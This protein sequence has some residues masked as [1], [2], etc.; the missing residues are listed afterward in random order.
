[1]NVRKVTNQLIEYAEEGIINWE[2]LAKSALRYMS[3]YEVAE[4][5]STEGYSELINEELIDEY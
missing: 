4:M 1:M 5:S 3:E 2:Q